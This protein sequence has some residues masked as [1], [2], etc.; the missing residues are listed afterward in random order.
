MPQY[1]VPLIM[2]CWCPIFHPQFQFQVG[3]IQSVYM[4]ATYIV[5]VPTGWIWP[6]GRD[7]IAGCA[8]GAITVQVPKPRH[9]RGLGRLDDARRDSN[10]WMGLLAFFGGSGIGPAGPMVVGWTYLHV[11]YWP[12]EE[13]PKPHPHKH[14]IWVLLNRRGG[15]FVGGP[16]LPQATPKALGLCISP[17]VAVALRAAQPFPSSSARLRG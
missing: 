9:R 16:P 1:L 4:A 15:G 6:R 7:E 11:I 10:N 5:I 3:S 2:P 14:S 12:E 17:L 13:G 8:N